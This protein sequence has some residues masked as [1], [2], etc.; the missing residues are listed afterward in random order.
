MSHFY[1]LLTVMAGNDTIRIHTCC[2][3]GRAKQFG[4]GEVEY[5]SRFEGP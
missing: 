4:Q 3:H 1:S 5:D 2:I